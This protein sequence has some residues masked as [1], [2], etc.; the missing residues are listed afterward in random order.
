M[1]KKKRKRWIHSSLKFLLMK[2]CYPFF[3]RCCSW[4]TVDKNKV[5]FVEGRLPKISNSFELLY[6][7]LKK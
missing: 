1:K 3:Y 2:I 5:I 6:N 7:L 4:K